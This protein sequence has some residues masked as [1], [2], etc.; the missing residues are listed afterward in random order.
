VATRDLTADAL[1]RAFLDFFAERGHTVVPSSSLIP[2]DPS[3]LLTT[4][5]MVQFKPYMLG[6][7]AAPWPRAT[8]VQK[9]FRTTDIDIVGTTSRHLTFFE[10]LGNFSLGDYFKE[11]AIPYAWEFVTEVLGFDPAD[12]WVTVHVTDDE[13]EQIW[14]DSVGVPAERIQRLDDDNFWAMGPTGPCGPCSEIFVDRG[15][16]YGA[17][18][19]PAHGGDER[20]IEIW[21]LVFMQYNRQGSGELVPLPRRNIDTGSGLER[22][23]QTALGLDSVYDTDVLRRIVAEAERLT[24]HRYGADEKRDVS[25]RILAEHA[26]AMTFLV[27]DGV[28]PT[29]EERG[30]VLRRII[31]RA[32]RH[33]YLLGVDDAVT[34]VLVDAALA[35]MGDAYPQLV[36]A[37]DYVRTVTGREEERFRATLRRGLE[38]LDD[39]VDKGDVGGDE[40]FH[41]HDTLGFP[42]DLTR[43]I[44]EERGR[45]V[46]LEGFAARMD[47][48]RRQAREARK[49]A[50]TATPVDRYREVLD[51]F[52]ASTFAGYVDVEV[53]G[54]RV[55]ALLVGDELVDGAGP[56]TEVDVVL[57]RTPFYAEAGGQVGDTGTLTGA[58][59]LVVDVRDTVWGLPSTLAVHKAVV[60]EGR[61]VPGA[62]VVAAIDADRRARI[63]RHHTATHL[64]HWALREV[65]GSHVKQAGSLVAP[66]RLRFDF[67][68]HEGVSSDQLAQVERLANLEVLSGADVETVET[69]KADAEQMGAIAFFGDKYGD[70]VRVLKAGG[71]SLEFCGGTHV[72]SLGEIGPV[73]ILSEGSIGSNNRRIEAVAGEAALDVIAA[74]EQRLASV[75]TLLN[76]GTADVPERVRALSDQVRE[77]QRELDRLRQQAAAGQAV[78]LAAGARDGVASARVD[79]I[80]GDDLR[81]LAIAVRDELGSGVAVLGALSPDGTKAGLAVAVSKDLQA[82]GISAADLAGD[83]AKLL[84]GGTAKNPDA[85][86]GGGPE[87]GR[88]DEAVALATERAT[89]A[90]AAGDGSS[91]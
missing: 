75:A 87:V 13:A 6:D 82:R 48:Q 30:Y 60:R 59:G 53:A 78:Q 5:G 36:T 55:L 18:G 49:A 15:A 56:G 66:D 47:A 26:R 35:T 77:L 91:S 28:V 65:L 62:E 7:E 20:F 70:Q 90:I 73:R 1:R 3:I 17:D 63:R 85:V 50:H 52:G 81:R 51:Q 61:L 42:I 8:S 39:L 67:S 31:R 21:N 86:V 58:D 11:G 89:T 24:G 74:D 46:D 23:L 44:A 76:V 84:R 41:L 43:E 72:H 19:G 9:C 71:H 69:S 45:A 2:A 34:G 68:H 4:A 25:L 80:V 32:V 33:A 79:G 14:L 64:L 10:M 37:R 57:D 54:A 83:A 38:L 40:A 88:L 27:A 16:S 29:N 12:L 22:V